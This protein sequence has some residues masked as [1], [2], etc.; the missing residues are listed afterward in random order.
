MQVL[1]GSTEPDAWDSKGVAFPCAVVMEDGTCRLYYS[2]SN[3]KSVGAS[4][5]GMAI[6]QGTDWSKFTRY[7]E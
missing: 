3:G 1:A 5:I 6:S 2:W 4:G 7:S